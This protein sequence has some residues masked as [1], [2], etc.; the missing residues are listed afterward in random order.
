MS[1]VR[2]PLALL[3]VLAAT[4]PACKRRQNA[5]AD[6]PPARGEGAAPLPELPSTATPASQPA[7]TPTEGKTTGTLFAH[8]E[9]Q[10]APNASGVIARIPVK[11]GDR[12]KKGQLLFQLDTRDAV[13]RKNAAQSALDAAKVNLKATQVE[14]DRT[15]ALFDQDAVNRAQ[16]EQ[17]QARLEGA[18]VGVQQAQAAL[19]MAQKAIADG[20]VRSP[21]DGV[22]TAKLK[23]EGE[24]ATMM[25]P[26][27]VVFVQDQDV[28]ELRFRLPERS[29]ASVKPGSSVKATFGAIRATKT[30]TI[31]RVQP[32]V[33]PR[34]RTIEVIAELPNADLAL[35]PGLLA[36]VE[37]VP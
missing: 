7:V 22:V 6:L 9:A 31:V 11:E 36:E 28:L 17:M 34:T 37:L 19:A 21:L 23:N 3:M 15:K 1:S 16:W 35:K 26:T 10:L 4:G 32:T 29:L 20:S 12:V 24:M 30:A 8:A 2:A 13:L 25:P 33:D 14:H 18:Q 27:I 5:A